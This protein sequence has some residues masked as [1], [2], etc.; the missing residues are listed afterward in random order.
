MAFVEEGQTHR[1]AVAQFRDSIKFVNDMVKLKRETSSL[2]PKAQGNGSWS[3]LGPYD[4]WAWQ[5]MVKQGEPTPEA[6]ARALLVEH[7]V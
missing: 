3:K 2:E 7:G 5:R 4:D 1:A 6:L